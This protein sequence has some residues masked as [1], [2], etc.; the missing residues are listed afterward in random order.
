MH[1]IGLAMMGLVV[2]GSAVW[3]EGLSPAALQEKQALCTTKGALS[4]VCVEFWRDVIAGGKNRPRVEREV[5]E[6]LMTCFREAKRVDE[7]NAHDAPSA[8]KLLRLRGKSDLGV[9]NKYVDECI[10][11]TGQVM[12]GAWKSDAQKA[13]FLDKM[14]ASVNADFEAKCGTRADVQRE[15]GPLQLV[16]WG[17]TKSKAVVWQGEDPDVGTLAVRCD[18]YLVGK[19]KEGKPISIAPTTIGAVRGAQSR[20]CISACEM[21]DAVCVEGQRRGKTSP[22]CAR[23]C[24]DKCR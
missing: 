19:S 12:G 23:Y 17:K 10:R 3:A 15:H 1:R 13:V 14:S 22:V 6:D 18:G 24:A 8:E 20:G 4:G 2:V 7:G 16:L 9:A 5:E 11:V 21:N